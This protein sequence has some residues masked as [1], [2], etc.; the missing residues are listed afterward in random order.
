MSEFRHVGVP[1]R[2]PQA[3]ETYIEGA[4]VH[5]TDPEAHPYRF[6]FLRFEAGSPMPNKLQT[7][8]HVAFEVKD[9]AA[10]LKGEEV[11]VP[12]FDATPTLQV[13]FIVKDGL[14]VELMQTK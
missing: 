11:V 9:L 2:R 3:N 7:E 12:P 8:P 4:K 1:T 5:V 10:A 14:L 13:A 6:E